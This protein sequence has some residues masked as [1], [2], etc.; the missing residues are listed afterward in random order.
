MKGE[1]L[2]AFGLTGLI[3][4]ISIYMSME[5]IEKQKMM[6]N[7]LDS[8]YNF[9]EYQGMVADG[10]AYWYKDGKEYVVDYTV[11]KGY[12]LCDI[13]VCG[14]PYTIDTLYPIFTIIIIAIIVIFIT[15]RYRDFIDKKEQQFQKEIGIRWLE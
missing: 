10:Y 7:E 8:K 2:I 9:S 14:D 13:K 1:T 6:W 4:V 11:E 12:F 5:V 3:I 15:L